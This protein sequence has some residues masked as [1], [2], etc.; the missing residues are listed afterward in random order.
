MKSAPHLPNVG[1]S[2]QQQKGSSIRPNSSLKQAGHV[3]FKVFLFFNYIR[4][5]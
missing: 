2:Q 5:C 3:Y 1:Q 4:M